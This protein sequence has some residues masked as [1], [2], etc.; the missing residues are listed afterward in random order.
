MLLVF[1]VGNTNIFFGLFQGE[2]LVDTFRLTSKTERTADELGLLLI[3]LL[4]TVEIKSEDINGIIVSSVVP[5]ITNL[6]EKT[7]AKYFKAEAIFIGPGVKTGINIRTDNP[8]EVGADRIVNVA[9]AHEIYKRSCIVVDFGT[10]TTFDYIS[11]DGVFKYTIIMPGLN[12]AAKALFTGTAKLP[13]VEIKKPESILAS[14]TVSGMQAGIVYGYIGAVKYTLQEQCK[15]LHDN[16]LIIATGGISE[17]FIMQIPEID[18]FDPNLALEGM[19]I[20]YKKTKGIIG[21][22]ES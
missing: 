14:N 20:I 16:P 7:F 13:D 6:L 1:D 21:D 12:L 4:E 19:K 5:S 18:V 8:K 9:A 15:A 10:A 3:E 17:E 11:T 22:L 2:R